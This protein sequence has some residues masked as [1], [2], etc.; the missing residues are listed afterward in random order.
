MAEEFEL[1]RVEPNAKNVLGQPLAVCGTEPLTGFYRSGCCE[2]GAD[3]RGV[4]TVCCLVDTAF[5]LFLK[6]AG[7]DLITPQPHFPGLKSGDRWCV[8]AASWLQAYQVGLA[9]KVVLEST[10]ARTLQIIPLEFLLEHAI[11]SARPN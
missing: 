11:T 2:S 1:E 3:D 8:C 7:N 5:L 9:C 6:Q 4:H 10:H